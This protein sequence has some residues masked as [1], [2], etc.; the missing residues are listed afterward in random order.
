MTSYNHDP[1]L[2][3]VN[4]SASAN[5]N[6][7][8]SNQLPAS[9]RPRM[10]RLI[11]GN[12][13]DGVSVGS[14]VESSGR[15]MSPATEGRGVDMYLGNHDQS[16]QAP[17]QRLPSPHPSR[18]SL[19]R[20]GSPA[21]VAG[22]RGG[23]TG[24][25]VGHGWDKQVSGAAG[26]NEG[27]VFGTDFWRTSFSSLQSIA[28]AALGSAGDAARTTGAMPSS[29]RS[30]PK[31]GRGSAAADK[32]KEWGPSALLGATAAPGSQ[33]ERQELV[34]AR[35]REALLQGDEA[36]DSL[37]NYKRRNSGEGR[38][39]GSDAASEPDDSHA[40]VYIHHVQQSDSL[41]SVSIRYG[42]PLP[43]LRKANG[44]WP[45]DSIQMR[46]TVL[47]PVDSCSIK[48]RRLPEPDLLNDDTYDSFSASS[49][50]ESPVS[51]HA[52]FN[53]K[54][55]SWTHECWVE[56]DSFP[57]PVEI[58]RITCR[59]L[60]YFPRSRRKSLTAPYSDF[61]ESTPELVSTSPVHQQSA[62][63][64]LGK[65]HPL[66]EARKQRHR[67]I[68]NNLSLAGPGGVGSLD[69][70]A[71]P[72]PAVDKL[73]SFV[74]THLPTLTLPPPPNQEIPHMP[75][76]T[77]SNSLL[78]PRESLDSSVSSGSAVENMS[79]AIEGWMRKMAT[80][81]KVGLSELQQ[82]VL[83]AQ[84]ESS[85]LGIGG[86]GDLIE[87]GDH[88]DQR[89]PEREHEELSEASGSGTSVQGAGSAKAQR[90]TRT[91]DRNG[92]RDD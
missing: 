81:A 11:S 54:S 69:N 48:G 84:G 60:G 6:S 74:Q 27:S 25:M 40:L 75:S 71:S 83:D 7:N 70:N 19:P 76:N 34:R 58:G 33:E 61:G 36:V 55:V 17:V 51:S 20:S 68:Y 47:L 3:S 72:G 22:Q 46:K 78:P 64:S 43:I 86:V 85:R 44:F 73:N 26:I 82:Q 35:K 49:A 45:S 92:L 39:R 91:W 50:A 53:S 62:S 38:G 4:P 52:G 67:R 29:L 63:P 66:D 5:A 56:I 90:R 88:R 31:R 1:P 65:P 23:M 15:M 2:I 80:R 9:V 18:A 10:R 32:P 30:K 28:S 12:S 42:C 59:A 41:M 77:S 57:S 87:L 24:T 14:S 89:R 13:N 37:G 79:G 16:A 8:S 21:V